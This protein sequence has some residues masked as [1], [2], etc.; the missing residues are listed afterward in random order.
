MTASVDL[1]KSFS[2]TKVVS[3]VFGL[4]IEDMPKMLGFDDMSFD[5]LKQC[6]GKQA[7]FPSRDWPERLDL[8]VELAAF[9]NASVSKKPDEVYEWLMKKNIDVCRGHSL[10][11]I[12]L[13][14]TIV[15][16]QKSMAHL[17][18]N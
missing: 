7:E 11:S 4:K 1:E 12:I 5:T 6:F 3:N 14:G 8:L 13:D 17:R 18:L 10:R 15:E 16:L 9:C 2:G